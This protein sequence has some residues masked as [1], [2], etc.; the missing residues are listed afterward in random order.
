MRHP[1]ERP[2]PL[3]RLGDPGVRSPAPPPNRENA[4]GS[5]EDDD[6][7]QTGLS[8]TLHPS[9]TCGRPNTRQLVTIET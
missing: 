1:N 8:L 6:L 7:F 5:G 9:A 4:E 3:G 2:R